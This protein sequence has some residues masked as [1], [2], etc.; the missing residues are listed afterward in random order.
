M[1][2][3]INS[4]DDNRLKADYQGHLITFVHPDTINNKKISVAL[5]YST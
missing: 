1:G 3:H 5:N 2:S 4:A